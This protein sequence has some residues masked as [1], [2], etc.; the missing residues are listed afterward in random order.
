MLR[1][2]GQDDPVPVRSMGGLHIL[3]IIYWGKTRGWAVKAAVLLRVQVGISERESGLM[4]EALLDRRWGS[5]VSGARSRHP[6][7]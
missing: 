5:I 4:R 2:G 7:C 6:T 1:R 3:N